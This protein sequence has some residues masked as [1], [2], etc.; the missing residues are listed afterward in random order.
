MGF[1]ALPT[2]LW[3]MW[4]FALVVPKYNSVSV[5]LLDFAKTSLPSI[6]MCVDVGL[7]PTINAGRLSYSTAA[8]VVFVSINVPLIVTLF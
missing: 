6:S 8:F 3:P 2:V 5:V 1:D 7:P 4:T